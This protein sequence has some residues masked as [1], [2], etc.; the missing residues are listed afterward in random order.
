MWNVGSGLVT[1][2]VKG[3]F[4]VSEGWPAPGGVVSPHSARLQMSCILIEN[5][6]IGTCRSYTPGRALES[7]A[8]LPGRIPAP[9]M[10]LDTLE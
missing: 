7:G 10:A 8:T 2:H 9:P 3:T 4:A 6:E 5:T 1:W